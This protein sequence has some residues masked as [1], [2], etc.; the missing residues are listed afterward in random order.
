M[1]LAANG[2]A[3]PPTGLLRQPARLRIMALLDR[4]GDV[5]FTEARTAL[6]LTPGNLD[7]HA[8]KLAEAG[9]L[10]SRRALLRHGFEVRLR[11]TP[12]GVEAFEAAVAE[13]ERL[14]ADLK[15]PRTP[16]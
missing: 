13:L 12:E 16:G 10:R 5:G 11:I 14:V 7:A 1:T 9:L 2:D 15:A 6:G 8:R 4:H 3:A